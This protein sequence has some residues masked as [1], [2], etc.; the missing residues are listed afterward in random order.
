MGARY[1]ANKDKSGTQGHRFYRNVYAYESQMKRN[2][3]GKYCDVEDAFQG[4]LI[5]FDALL[6]KLV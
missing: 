6:R 5:K 4:N 1:Q 3:P 2:S